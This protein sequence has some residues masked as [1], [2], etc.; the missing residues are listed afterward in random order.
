M[1]KYFLILCSIQVFWSEAIENLF[2][3]PS[4]NKTYLYE[5]KWYDQRVD[6]FNFVKNE[7]FKQRYLINDTYWDQARSGPIFFYTGNEGDIEAFAQNSGFVWDTAP[8]FK[9]LIIF[10][11]HRYYGKSLPFGNK[12]LNPDPAFNGYLTS[13]QALADYAQLLTDIKAT[14]Q[15]AD[16]SPVI[17]F[18]GS[19]GGMLAAW[20]R[21][22]YPHI[23]AGAIAA[24]APVAQ[25]DAPC[26]AFGRIVT[27]DYTAENEACS[28]AIRS[29]WASIDNVTSNQDGLDWINKEFK[30]CKALKDK[31]D[32]TGFKDFLNDLWTNVA[33]MD[34]PYKTTFLMPLPGNPVKAVCD[35]ITG[36]LV[37][38]NPNA[39]NIIHAIAG[40]VN[41]YTNFTGTSKCT[42][43]AD[44]DQ[45]G[46]DMWDY[47][48]CTEMVMPMCFDGVNDM[49]ENAPWNETE[50]AANCKKKWKIDPQPK[51][52]DLMYGSK[53]LF[54]ASNIVF[55]NGLLD[56]WSSGGILKNVS[57][58]VIAILIPEG[59]HHLDLRGKN[60]ADPFSVKQARKLEREYMKK[61]INQARANLN[62]E[63]TDFGIDDVIDDGEDDNVR[64][65]RL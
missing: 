47:Q 34:Y 54:G 52:A 59:A 2:A 38:E 9:A 61:W 14:V 5:T 19:Y 35:V 33:M 41:I 18:G 62:M 46:A 1:L 8:A 40:G 23:C 36:R 22:K 55:S 63:L 24:S 65:T 16:K 25:F 29:S 57:K 11:E 3:P 30:F 64:I 49:F 21:Y 27:A 7:V 4:A 10:A 42:N 15:G 48:A 58:S 26:D 53:A 6:H 44:Q 56:P 12:S 17:A 39:K 45:I 31:N 60:D 50:Y 37:Q 13:E 20:F 51:M 32:V 28:S 43:L